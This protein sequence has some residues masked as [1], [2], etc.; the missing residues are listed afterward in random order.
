MLSMRDS[1]GGFASRLLKKRAM[2][3]CSPVALMR[4]PRLSF[5]TYPT[6]SFSL[7]RRHTVGLKPTP[8]TVPRTRIS[9]ASR[10]CGCPISSVA[11]ASVIRLDLIIRAKL[12]YHALLTTCI[13]QGKRIH[14]KLGCPFR[15]RVLVV[16]LQRLGVRRKHSGGET[17][18]RGG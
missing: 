9:T 5:S 14:C 6:R 3:F 16:S 10:P 17:V 8:C 15:V 12:I 2:R 13:Q 1:G 11:A 4:T 18:C 7:A